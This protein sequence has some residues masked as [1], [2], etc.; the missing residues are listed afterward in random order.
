MLDAEEDESDEDNLVLDTKLKTRKIKPLRISTMPVEQ[1]S[2]ADADEHGSYAD[3]MQ[4]PA[5]SPKVLPQVV[6]TMNLEDLS[7]DDDDD[8]YP[9]FTKQEISDIKKLRAERQQEATAGGA[10][11][12]DP[13]FSEKAYVRMLDREDKEDLQELLGRPLHKGLSDDEELQEAEPGMISDGRLALSA[14]ELNAEALRRKISIEEALNAD[15]AGGAWE[16]TQLHKHSRAA[17][18][19]FYKPILSSEL[20]KYDGLSSKQLAVN[21]LS[22]GKT[23][24]K[25]SLLQK[26]LEMVRSEILTLKERQSTLLEE[27]RSLV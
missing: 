4:A 27:A 16:S 17:E 24:Q 22:Q 5:R 7:D 23:S 6:R 15:L 18:S 20:S 12:Q 21:L 19:R 11:E 13:Q 25:I 1:E 14:S 2:D 8:A 9:V 10:A 3:L 26:Q